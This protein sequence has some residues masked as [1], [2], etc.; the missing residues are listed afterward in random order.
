MESGDL[1]LVL[2]Y[3]KGE[4]EALKSLLER[5]KRPLFRFILNSVGQGDDAD[6]I[7]QEVWFRAIKKMDSYRHGNFMGWLFRICHNL[8]V[9]RARARQ[10][11]LSLDEENEEGQSMVDR[12]PAEGLAPSL[13]AA[14]GELGRR[15]RAAV[16]ALPAEQKEVFLLRTEAD[17]PF[18]E[19]ARVQR[20][21]I[22][23]AL[24]RMHYA[25]AKL[26]DTLKVD[27]EML[28]AGT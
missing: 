7:F 10:R 18:K 13:A 16:G 23:T 2:R 15:I 9:D 22:N 12:I 19:I 3:Q 8:I 11:V 1:E 4:V 28:R 26:R 21:S 25:V 17:M 5:Y 14:D 6:E 20:V 27:Y 24:A